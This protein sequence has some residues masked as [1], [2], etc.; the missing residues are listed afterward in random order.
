MLC[1]FLCWR[2]SIFF[3]I[4]FTAFISQFATWTTSC[5]SLTCLMLA[6]ISHILH[7]LFY[8]CT[9]KTLVKW[10]LHD[11][12]FHVSVFTTTS[13][14]GIFHFAGLQT[15]YRCSCPF[16]LCPHWALN[17]HSLSFCCRRCSLR[18][19]CIGP[20]L[21]TS[22]SR[23]QLRFAAAPLYFLSPFW[24]LFL[25]CSASFWCLCVSLQTVSWYHP[26]KG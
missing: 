4:S 26:L 23:L 24:F 18:C 10:V 20:S 15:Q 2:G 1:M 5:P 12:H 7:W 6:R 8:H 21:T 22:I 13:K 17:R 3:L 25:F 16:H 14:G 19:W 9:E 11:L